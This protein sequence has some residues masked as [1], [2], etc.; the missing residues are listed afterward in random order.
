M[1]SHRRKEERQLSLQDLPAS[2]QHQ[3]KKNNSVRINWMS[4]VNQ[5]LIIKELERRKRVRDSESKSK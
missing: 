1:G 3:A 5:Q 2:L 4:I